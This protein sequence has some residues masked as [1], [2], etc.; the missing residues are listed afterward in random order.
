[1]IELWN[2]ELMYVLDMDV[3][4]LKLI[5]KDIHDLNIY[6]LERILNLTL[7]YILI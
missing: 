5:L 1:M 2:Y 6:F 7:L 4:N 3:V